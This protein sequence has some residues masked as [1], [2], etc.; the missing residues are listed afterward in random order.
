MKL[1]R[2][3]H[4]PSN[5]T[6]QSIVRSAMASRP[7]MLEKL[8]D[9]QLMSITLDVRTASGGKTAT[10]TSVG[11]VVNLDLYAVISGSTSGSNDA[12][13]SATGSLLSTESNTSTSLVGNLLAS[14][15]ANNYGAQGASE[16]T[17]QDLNGDGG[18]DVGSNNNGDVSGFMNA[19]AG[20]ENFNGTVS[21]DTSTFLLATVTY[22]VTKLN[23][24]QST[25]VN[26]RYRDGIPAGAFDAV[27]VEDQNGEND[28]I[29]TA[30][31]GTPVVITDPNLSPPPA[32]GSI[33]GT[34]SKV[35]SGSTS[36]FAG[37][38]MDLL[39]GNSTI[40]TTTTGSTGAYS[41]SSLVAGSYSVQEV[42]PT[43]YTETSPSGN[44]SVSL[45]A[46]QNATGENFTDT[47]NAT[48]PTSGQLTGTAIGTAGS[49]GND[50]DTI[51]KAFDGSLTDFFDGPNA[52]GD[53]V[54]LDLGSTYTI[55]SV[56]Y[57]P[58]STPNLASR[59]VGGI[60]QGSNTADFSS[61]VT[62]LFTISAAPAI[63]V[64]TTA[65][66]TNTSAFRYVRYLSPNGGYGNIAELE[67]FGKSSGAVATGGSVSGTV[68]GASNVTVYLDANNN[69]VL[70]SGE[71]STTTSGSYSFSGVPVGTYIVR[72]VVPSGYTQTTPSSGGYTVVITNGSTAT[73]ENFVDTANSTSPT[74][75]KLTG[76][77]IGTSGSY[78]NAGNT[79]AKALDGN[80]T[81]F[82][83]G[84][85]ANGN[86]VGLDLGSTYTIS[87][88]AFSP[89]SSP[90][91]ASRMVG[92]IFQASNTADFSSGV[93]NLYTVSTAPADS[94]LTT[95]NVSNSTAYRYVRYLSPNGSYGDV[96]EVQFFGTASGTVTPPPTLTQFTGT[97]IGTSGSYQNAGNTIAKATDGNL[98][99]FFDGA[100]AN[101]NWVG[102]DLGSAKIVQ[103]ISFAPRSS[104]NLASRMVG[105]IFQ[106]S[107]T[108]DFSSGVVNLYTIT[109]A[110]SG[111]RA[112]HRE[113]ERRNRIPLLPLPLP[114]RQLRRYRGGRVLRLIEILNL[115]IQRPPSDSLGGLLFV[116][117]YPPEA[118]TPVM[119]IT[120]PWMAWT[121]SW[122]R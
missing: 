72:E 21:G 53:W 43:G 32:T 114:Q 39:S 111:Q 108:A 95:V 27:W 77:A 81:T 62:N 9:R 106:A 5:R 51:A 7:V 61:G 10:V 71:L 101:G 86:W 112:N 50:G 69:G 82:Y 37:V 46:G 36:T 13:L 33:A 29:G 92:G 17:Q 63:N 73:G 66:I 117:K 56:S 26:F 97:T 44:I 87:Q 91:L 121:A 2:F 70:D 90:N 64:L 79:I 19:R 68:S 116:R 12:V 1:N 94:V 18:L 98:S 22:T 20:G 59:M 96:S 4:R 89:R 109:T 102:L 11:Q 76:T 40:A 80:L 49:Y 105:G 74:G 3:F 120:C 110:P 113:C 100:S 85:S 119:R 34:V 58:R 99:T 107:N 42:V 48:S 30:L 118:V 83:D 54:G 31:V 65:A 115:K 78:Q 103:Q 25:S 93:V 67:F 16:G 6:K 104:P 122:W 45:S 24:G 47:A 15:D 55:T 28:Q 75:T 8:E 14:V 84:A 38:T 57:A 52:N 88:I 60:I 41:F 35:V 23:Y